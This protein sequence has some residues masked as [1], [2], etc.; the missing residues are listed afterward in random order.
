MKQAVSEH[1]TIP[2]TSQVKKYLTKNLFLTEHYEL[3]SKDPF[4]TVILNF[5]ER[6]SKDYFP[7]HYPQDKSLKIY[8]GLNTGINNKMFMPKEK[9]RLFNRF[10]EQLMTHELCVHLD[11]LRVHTKVEIKTGIFDFRK[12]YNLSEEEMTYEKAKK[13]YF[14]YRIRLK[15]LIDKAA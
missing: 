14:R 7:L 4:G 6:K 2:V 1:I 12:K 8:L 3:S 15:K 13:A 9:A 5:L 10:T 11:I